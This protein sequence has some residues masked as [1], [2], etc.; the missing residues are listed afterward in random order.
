MCPCRAFMAPPLLAQAAVSADNVTPL[1]GNARCDMGDPGELNSEPIAPND[2]S[3]SSSADCIVSPQEAA[4][5]NFSLT[6][7]DSTNGYGLAA[8]DPWLMQVSPIDGSLYSYVQHGDITG[9]SS[10]TS[11]ALGG[12][13]LTIAGSGFAYYPEDNTVLI[14]G[15]PCVVLSTTKTSL[16]CQVPPSPSPSAASNQTYGG[17]R[18]LLLEVGAHDGAI[19]CM[20]WLA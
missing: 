19:V 14:G 12:A 15:N 16:K 4:R 17:G 10:S 11:G 7:F 2:W 1:L 13:T 9:L 5:V 3:S 18:G 8:M 6:L 20:H